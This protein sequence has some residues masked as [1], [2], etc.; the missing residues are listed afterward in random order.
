MSLSPLLNAAPVIQAHAYCAFLALALGCVQMAA[1][2]GSP[3]HRSLGW[4]W[5]LAMMAAAGTSLFIHTIRTFGPFSP[6]HLLSLLT[7]I[8]APLAVMAARQRRVRSHRV[9]MTQLFA[10]ALVITGLF[11]FWPGRI[12]HQVAFG[13]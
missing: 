5:A 13:S 9:A 12:M 4:I 10:F 7:L 2:K 1:P 11:T 6:I 3:T 8:A